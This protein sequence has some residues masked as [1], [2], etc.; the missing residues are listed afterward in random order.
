MKEPV[1]SHKPSCSH[2]IFHLACNACMEFINQEKSALSV[3]DRW[4]ADP[5]LIVFE[6]IKPFERPAV[7]PTVR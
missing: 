1:N 3:I 2:Q 7:A 5:A 4:K 6:M